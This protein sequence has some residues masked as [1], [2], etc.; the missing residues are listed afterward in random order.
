MGGKIYS[1]TEIKH[2]TEKYGLYVALLLAAVLRILFLGLRPFDGDEGIIVKIAQSSGFKAMISGVSSDVH[3]P[4]FHAL[5]YFFL[6]IF[7][8]SEFSTRL[9]PAICGIIV[10]WPIYL[11]FKKLS[12]QRTAFYVSILS[13]LS[14]VLAYHSAEVRPY[15][16]FT[17]VFFW[18]FY[19][20]LKIKETKSL[21]LALSFALSTFFL[22]LTQHMGLFVLLGELLYL[23][24]L[25]RKSLTLNNMMSGLFGVGLFALLWGKIF[26]YQLSGRSFEQSQVLNLKANI[27]GLINAIYRFGAGR[28]FLDLDPSISKNI[29][30]FKASPFMFFI[31]VL[32]LL[33]PLTLLVWGMMLVFKKKRQLFWLIVLLVLPVFAAALLSSEIGPRAARYLSF[34][35]PF[36]LFFIIYPLLLIKK[37]QPYYFL[38]LIIFLFIFIASFINGL[39]FERSK[40]GVNNIAQYLNEH[41]QKNDTVLIRGGFGGGEELILN[42]YLKNRKDDFNVFDMYGDYR[43]GNLSTLKS[44]DLIEYIIESKKGSSSVWFYDLTYGFDGSSF[45]IM[46]FDKIEL[47]QDKENKDLNL[48][49]VK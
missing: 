23:V 2:F 46:P 6:Q 27:T 26:L 37:M 4:L 31:F 10:I 36:Y 25:D 11:V 13:V 47:G 35:V 33:V 15:A 49:H 1:M 9:I 43:V 3:P 48:Y 44:R 38:L 40:P 42:Y 45:A 19:M 28:L 24:C 22:I 14:S 21:S 17:L 7:Q 30:F 29:E 8:M 12:D 5:E 16:L 41:G 34:L 39:Y 20:F 32:S 18:Q